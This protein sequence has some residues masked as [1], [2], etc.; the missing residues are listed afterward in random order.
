MSDASRTLHAVGE[1]LRSADLLA[2]EP[3]P[4]DVAISGVCQDS[5]QAESGDLFLAWRGTEVDAHEFV[6]EA[7][8]RGAVA[9]V[10]ERPVDVSVPQLVVHDGRRA[11]A[12][13]A[14]AVMGSPSREL[15]T[16]GVTGTNG[17]TTTAL[18]IRHLIGPDVPAAVIGTLGVVDER[19]V[20]P[21]TENLTTPGPVQ[22]ALWLR[23]L[24]DGG[25]GAV[26]M[27]AS[28]HALEQHRLDGVLF[29]IGVFTNL[30]QDHLD[31]HGDLD[32]YFC[33]KAHLAHLVTPE[34]T[35]VVNAADPAWARLELNGRALRT[36]AV[37]LAADVRAYDLVLGSGGSSFTLTVDGQE[38]AART[39]LVG[40]YNVENTLA[41]IG[42]ARAAGVTT[43]AIVQRLA[44]APQASGRLEAVV[45]SPF[46]VLVDYAHTPAALEGALSAVKPLTSRRLIVV[47]GAGGDRDRT[48]RK[49]MAEAVRR[50][51]D[52]I[53]LT[54]DNP[55]TEDPERILDDVAEGLQGVSYE[56]LVDRRDAIRR[57]LE[58]AEPGDTVV[59]TGKGHET[60]Q[61][62]GGKKVP[63]DER[64]I[65]REL[66]SEMGIS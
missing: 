27:E 55:R 44:T 21:G 43:S 29:D 10:V 37:E 38:N 12:L 18:L 39:P 50:Y 57:A 65:V 15:V 31:Y 16:V 61:A 66:L 45:S 24:V 51:A 14:D 59:L 32:A 28:S 62:I 60:Y 33:A 20:R 2:R 36:Y 13:A 7:V 54:N 4:E 3:G 63:F 34:G 26:V 22:L 11:A 52:V 5:R 48:K 41:A 42:A 53:V 25:V 6:E 47:F 35:I 9:T 19:G 8:A 23:E 30:T 1:V 56:R 40:R 49:P 46:T 17:K 58:L 64:V